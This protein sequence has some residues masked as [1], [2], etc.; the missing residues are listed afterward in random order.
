MM[1]RKSMLFFG[2]LAGILGFNQNAHA[3]IGCGLSIPG[4][5]ATIHRVIYDRERLLAQK[6]RVTM[7]PICLTAPCGKIVRELMWQ[8]EVE[9]VIEGDLVTYRDLSTKGDRLKLIVDGSKTDW[10][11]QHPTVV[12]LNSSSSYVIRCKQYNE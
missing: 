6:M 9:K 1:N 12:L 4:K 11:G 7:P 5:T 3:Q 8:F 2:L 10:F